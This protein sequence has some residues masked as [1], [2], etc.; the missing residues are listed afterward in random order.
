MKALQASFYRHRSRSPD[1]IH[2]EHR[3]YQ[4]T[5]AH[6]GDRVC[7]G[8]KGNDHLTRLFGD[9]VCYLL[10]SRLFLVFTY[11]LFFRLHCFISKV[12]KRTAH[13]HGLKIT[14]KSSKLSCYHR[15]SVGRKLH[16]KRGIEIIYCLDKPHNTL[17]KGQVRESLGPLK[18]CKTAQHEPEIAVYKLLTG[19]LSP[20]WAFFKS[21]SFSDLFQCF[22]LIG[23]HSAYLNFIV[24]HRT[25]LLKSWHF[26]P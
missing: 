21:S 24:L 11:E 10:N 16:I 6:R 4:N 13:P 5:Q 17:K 26:M 3:R 8:F 14:K 23:V 15:H 1:P 18:T 2:K 22:K 12:T 20:E 9:S 7:Y 25:L 19:F